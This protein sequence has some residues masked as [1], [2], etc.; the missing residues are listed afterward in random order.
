MEK[1]LT[2]LDKLKLLSD[3]LFHLEED[4]VTQEEF[5]ILT[6]FIQH[7]IELL[8]N[9]SA[10]KKE[11]SVA[12]AFQNAVLSVLTNEGVRASE[13]LENDVLLDF[14]SE[15][16]FPLRIQRITSALKVLADADNPNAP[17]ERFE[18]KKVAYF[19]LKQA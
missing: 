19:R 9:K 6:D 8:E 14:A 7:E 3:A 18:V 12:I 16:D 2:K 5:E 13:L 4:T 11:N 1:K 17:A 10:T 15:H